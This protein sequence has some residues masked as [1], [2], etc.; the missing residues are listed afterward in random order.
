VAEHNLIQAPEIL[1]RLADRFG[2]KQAHIL[3]TLN[4]GVQAVVILD[5]VTIR[6]KPGQ[7]RLAFCA[8][9]TTGDALTLATAVGIENPVGSGKV[10]IIEQVSVTRFGFAVSGSVW[11][12]YIPSATIPAGLG[13]GPSVDLDTGISVQNPGDVVGCFGRINAGS[14]PAPVRIWTL[15]TATATVESDDTWNPI[16]DAQPALN[17]GQCFLCQ[18][19]ATSG[20]I[21]VSFLYHTESQYDRQWPR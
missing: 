13:A 19:Q 5:D 1:K 10:V 18:D 16:Q 11:A 12:G 9:G 6:Q 14:I 3:P 20:Q 4:E 21:V 7:Q 8:T 17:P 15:P 2:M